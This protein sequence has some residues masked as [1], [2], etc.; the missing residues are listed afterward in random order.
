MRGLISACGAGLDGSS[1]GLVGPERLDEAFGE[2][3]ERAGGLRSFVYK[4]LLGINPPGR[5]EEDGAAEGGGDGGH[6][7]VGMDHLHR[8]L[9]GCGKPT[10]VLGS[11]ASTLASTR[12]GTALEPA[13]FASTQLGS[14]FHGTALLSGGSPGELSSLLGADK[15]VRAS[16]DVLDAVQTDDLGRTRRILKADMA[17]KA[18]RH[19]TFGD[20]ALH[21]AV[22]RDFGL[23]GGAPMTELLLDMGADPNA[24][25]HVQIGPLHAAVAAGNLEAVKR[26]LASGAD[27]RMEDRWRQ[28]PLHKAAYRGHVDLAK[29]LLKD[30]KAQGTLDLPDAWGTTPILMAAQHGHFEMLRLLL[31]HG[32]RLD[33]EDQL[34]KTALH[35]A[36]KGGFYEVAKELLAAGAKAQLTD[37]AGRTARDVARERGHTDLITLFRFFSRESHLQAAAAPVAAH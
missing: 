18:Q 36:A 13:F 24:G 27:M 23:S 30:A 29:L 33:S 34:G 25:D 17:A 7:A 12:D 31:S 3:V 28:T 10:S 11:T 8:T 21:L 1:P 20:T 37:R 35:H 26:L 4:S 16:F 2:S 32:A 6:G 19:D 22:P 9:G 14:T 5:E 15:S